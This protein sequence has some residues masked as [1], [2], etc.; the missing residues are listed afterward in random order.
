MAGK[1]DMVEVYRKGSPSI[2]S[3]G[4]LITWPSYHVADGKRYISTS[5]GPMATKLGRVVGSNAGLLSLRS[6]NL[7]ITWPYMATWQMK[8]VVNLLSRDLSLSNL[9]EGW[10]MIKQLNQ[11][12][13]VTG[14]SIHL[15][16]F[17]QKKSFCMHDFSTSEFYTFAFT[18]TIKKP[19]QIITAFPFYF[20]DTCQI[21]EINTLIKN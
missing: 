10:L 5:A 14:N 12:A 18:F 13:T 11:S 15:L 6:H 7:L 16:F 8:N 20:C 2:E 17:Q 4:A 19:A 9:T 21:I 3:F 1:I